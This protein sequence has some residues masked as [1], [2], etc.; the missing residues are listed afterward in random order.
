VAKSN[1]LKK[2]WNDLWPAIPPETPEL[3]WCFHHYFGTVDMSMGNSHLPRNQNFLVYFAL[4]CNQI[5]FFQ[6]KQ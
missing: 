6:L 3:R 1:L 4:F 2:R 5:V